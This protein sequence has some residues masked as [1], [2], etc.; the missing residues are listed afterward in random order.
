MKI[1]GFCWRFFLLSL[2]FSFHSKRFWITD[3]GK[4]I[5]HE[6]TMTRMMISSY[7][8]QPT[9]QSTEKKTKLNG[10]DELKRHFPL[11]QNRK[12]SS[13]IKKI[14]L[15]WSAQNILNALLLAFNVWYAH[16]S[17]YIFIPNSPF[18]FISHRFGNVF[19][20]TFFFFFHFGFNLNRTFSLFIVRRW[21][22]WFC[23]RKKTMR[24]GGL[25]I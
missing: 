9:K 11:K 21:K 5:P 25:T 13:W 2:L 24:N 16:C 19:L 8:Q 12:R 20:L 23:R 18:V 3:E 17:P 7:N 14:H 10:N 1:S 4:W 6:S 22:K 15:L